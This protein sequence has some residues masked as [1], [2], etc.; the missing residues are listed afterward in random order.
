MNTQ[1]IWKKYRT[2]NSSM[3]EFLSNLDNISGLANVSLEE[4]RIKSSVQLA[5]SNWLEEIENL[6]NNTYLWGQIIAPLQ[7]SMQP[8]GKPVFALFKSYAEK[9]QKIFPISDEYKLRAALLCVE[10]Y[11]NWKKSAEDLYLCENY[12]NRDRSFKNFL[13]SQESSYG[14]VIKKLID[15]WY[16]EFA[17]CVTFDELF[18]ELRKRFEPQDWR[19]HI[20]RNPSI[21]EFASNSKLWYDTN[22]EHM[23]LRQK[24]QSDTQHREIFL[25]YLWSQ[26]DQDK[27]I[28]L[29]WYP[30]NGNSNTLS[31][32][33]NNICIGLTNGGKYLYSDKNCSQQVLADEAI[34]EKLQSLH[35][36]K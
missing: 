22:T 27:A 12:F 19:K 21:L 16:A 35:I 18:E 7:W 24:L 1:N 23:F 36:M 28:I 5:D 25:A 20:V 3:R 31:I 34:I 8:S 26:I 17:D 30:E 32:S 14:E 11:G 13:R 4:E 15:L 29:D 9:L 6:E 2:Q 10:N 33:T